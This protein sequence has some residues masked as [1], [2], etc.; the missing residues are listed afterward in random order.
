MAKEKSNVI[1][2]RA[3]KLKLTDKEQGEVFILEK[4][5]CSEWI[6][7]RQS[8]GKRYLF[9]AGHIRDAYAYDMEVIA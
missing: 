9:F 7:T 2:R 3:T 1:P 5:E 8:D 4:N 6:G